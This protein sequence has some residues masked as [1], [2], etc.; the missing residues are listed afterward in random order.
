VVVLDDFQDF[1]PVRAK[2]LGNLILTHLD[3]IRR[4]V[5]LTFPNDIPPVAYDPKLLGFIKVVQDNSFGLTVK[6]G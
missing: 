5:P 1:T 3:E 4:G 6:N 2:S